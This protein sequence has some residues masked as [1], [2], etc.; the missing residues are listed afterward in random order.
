MHNNRALFLSAV[1]A[2]AGVCYSGGSAQ[3]AATIEW[4]TFSEQMVDKADCGQTA[5]MEWV[6]K[7]VEDGGII[8]YGQVVA[9]EAQE[10]NRWSWAQVA[11]ECEALIEGLT[12]GRVVFYA[13]NVL[14]RN[15]EG[16]I[17]ASESPDS[18][19]LIVGDTILV[20]LITETVG[21]RQGLMVPIY[22][23]FLKDGEAGM[24]DFVY[25][26]SSARFNPNLTGN[27]AEF[28]PYSDPYDYLTV[29]RKSGFRLRTVVEF[30]GLEVRE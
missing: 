13:A 22:I 5:N 6:A 7:S 1:L 26:Q 4:R 24:E 12:T 27:L 3:A 28:D 11:L 16:E 20:C 25:G 21:P 23:G 10:V 14:S 15:Q 9:I 2:L 29:V 18:P 17:L 30:L 19:W 8:A